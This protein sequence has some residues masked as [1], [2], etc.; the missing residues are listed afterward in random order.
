M[1]HWISELPQAGILGVFHGTLH[2]SWFWWLRNNDKTR[3]DQLLRDLLTG[4]RLYD[5]K[6]LRN[7]CGTQLAALCFFEDVEWACET[8]SSAISSIENNLDELEGV[9]YVAIAELLSRSEKEPV[10]ADQRQKALNF[11]LKLLCT[12]N[13]AFKTYVSNRKDLSSSDQ[14]REPPWLGQVFY[15]FHYVAME[16]QFSLKGHTK[17]WTTVQQVERDEKMAAWWGINEPILDVLLSMPHPGFTFHLIEGLE[18]L[19]CLDVQRTLHWLRRITLASVPMGLT[20]ESLAADHTIGILERIL[21]EHRVSLVAGS[22]E[23]SDFVQILDAY[24]QVG[25]PKAIRLAVQL[26]SI[27]R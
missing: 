25:W 11:L 15:F 27:F 23:R 20:N 4:V 7:A 6:E 19:V 17:Q 10:P 21:A 16:F 2:S 5:S 24:L 1:E 14:S 18:H 22:E 9:Q 3:A 26:E 8:I 13:Q 12:A